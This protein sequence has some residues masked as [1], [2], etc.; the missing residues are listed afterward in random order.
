MSAMPEDIL[1][2]DAQPAGALALE[3]ILTAEA[4]CAG[5]PRSDSLFE[6]FAAGA[7]A[8]AATILY[9]K[10]KHFHADEDRQAASP[11]TIFTPTCRL[12]LACAPR[13]VFSP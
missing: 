8:A 6:L 2:A 4:R 12:H 3:A 7:A 13:A 10:R 9:A 1:R 5:A 11:P